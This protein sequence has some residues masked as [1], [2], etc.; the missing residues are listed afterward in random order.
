MFRKT[1]IAAAVIAFAPP[2][3]AEDGFNPFR[4]ARDAAELGLDTAERAVDL[5]LDTAEEAADAAEDA[6]TLDDNCP[7]GEYYKGRDG[8]WH[9]CD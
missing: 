1:V 5:G 7:R 2:V 8:R 4:I 3:L 6:V 9:P